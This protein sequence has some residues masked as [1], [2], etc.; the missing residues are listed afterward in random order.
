MRG[1]RGPQLVQGTV[2]SVQKEYGFGA[3]AI[4]PN[5]VLFYLKDGRTMRYDRVEGPEFTDQPLDRMPRAG[6][7][8]A[9]YWPRRHGAIQLWTFWSE[10]QLLRERGPVRVR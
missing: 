6:D 4:G 9:C 10:Y 3:A 7:L 2:T 5:V 1:L 8:L